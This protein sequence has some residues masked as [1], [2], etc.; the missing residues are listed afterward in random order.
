MAFLK[1]LVALIA[2]VAV[3]AVA[4]R[5]APGAP[6]VLDL[7]LLVVV[8]NA[9]E[10]DPLGG[11]LGGFAAGLVHDTMAGGLF[12]LHGFANT[13]VGYLVS[14]VAQRF[15]VQQP[16]PAVLVFAIAAALQE[17]IL[18]TLALVL[19]AEPEIQPLVPLLL[20]VA[21]S[22]V[23]GLSL[24]LLRRRFRRQQERWRSSRGSR[25]RLS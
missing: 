10:G 18:T 24:F 13:V 22:A 17:A 25:L 8:F 3:E 6:R 21:I 19:F 4:T 5:L 23:L 1:Y 16:L 9:L 20:K 15:M 12:G 14:V 7:V 11:T 2:A